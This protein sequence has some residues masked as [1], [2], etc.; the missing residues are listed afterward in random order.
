MAH[1]TFVNHMYR[2][3]QQQ[4]F[5]RGSNSKFGLAGHNLA[6]VYVDDAAFLGTVFVPDHGRAAR[7][8]S[9]RRKVR[10]LCWP[11]PWVPERSVLPWAAHFCSQLALQGVGRHVVAAD[12]CPHERRNARSLFHGCPDRPDSSGPCERCVAGA[13]PP[14][15]IFLCWKN[16]NYSVILRGLERCDGNNGTAAPKVGQPAWV[17]AF[18][19]ISPWNLDWRVLLHT[20]PDSHGRAIIHLNP[21]R[22]ADISEIWWHKLT[23]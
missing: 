22:M 18:I 2:S 15:S 10:P 14:G 5:L 17:E 4:G 11:W 13:R 19:W 1:V 20:H 8:V 16:G 21:R 12:F 9:R 23:A 6:L 7:D 3:W